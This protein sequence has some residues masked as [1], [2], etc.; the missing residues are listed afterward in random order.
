MPYKF[1]QLIFNMTSISVK[2][3]ACCWLLMTFSTVC[4][5]QALY[6]EKINGGDYEIPM[7]LIEEG[8]FK[9]GSPKLEQGHFG[10]EGPQHKVT[11]DG[12][13]MSQYEVTWDLYNLFVSR[14]LDGKQLPKTAKSEVQI[15]VDGVSGATTPYVEM[16]FGMGVDNYPAICMT[17]LAAVKFCEWLSA[18]TGHF[19]R[20]PTE[21]EWE[22]ACRAG[23]ETAYSFGDDAGQLTEYAWY[24]ENSEDKYQKVGT[25]K[26]NPWGLYDMHGNVAEWTLD[27]Y[28]PT[29]YGKRTKG[30]SNPLSEG[31]KVY[32]K[33]VRGGS[34]MDGP[35]RLRSAARRPSSK[36]WKKRDPQIPKSKWWHTDAP[37]VGFRIVRPLETPSEEEQKKYW[38][39]ELT[40]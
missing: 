35:N 39:Y 21:A 33:A 18:M 31:E 6:F 7:V 17:Q 4:F 27:Q 2:F 9:M 12:F 34:W 3:C 1:V 26:P 8:A 20:L 32:P 13:W 36:K 11:V 15:D 16:S 25:K 38:K 10:D 28:I 22:Y 37:F 24:A 40:D 19:Y 30:V 14:E 23:T 29:V 5:S